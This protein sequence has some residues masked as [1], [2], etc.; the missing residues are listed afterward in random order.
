MSLYTFRRYRDEMAVHYGADEATTSD[1]ITSIDAGLTDFA[2]AVAISNA[3]REVQEY[4]TARNQRWA[5][6]SEEVTYPASSN[7]IR[8]EGDGRVL[9]S[10]PFSLLLVEEVRDTLSVPIYSAS[11]DERWRGDLRAYP[12]AATLTGGIFELKPQP[13]ALTLRFTYVP[14]LGHITRADLTSE[15]EDYEIPAAAQHAV[16]LAA[17]KNLAIRDRTRHPLLE[18][19]LARA[20]ARVSE[21][22]R[23]REGH[24]PHFIRNTRP[25]MGVP[26]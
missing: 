21:A 10:V 19:E 24:S 9:R 14:L 5:A 8:I 11:H 18:E 20:L 13:A 25:R 3:R 23:L 4:L 7:G 22:A 2:M 1:N 15:R 26:R 12:Y 17:A 16:P 6:I